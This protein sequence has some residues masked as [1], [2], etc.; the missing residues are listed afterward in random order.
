M[1]DTK[2]LIEIAQH[3][4]RDAADAVMLAELS[5]PSMKDWH[6]GHIRHL[7]RRAGK[8]LKAAAVLPRPRPLFY[9]VQGE[10]IT[11]DRVGAL[12]VGRLALSTRRA[13]ALL[14]LWQWRGVARFA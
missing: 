3:R 12:K 14:A 2:T 9:N 10:R 5:R 8:A 11:V 7:L 4:L 13:A 1:K 6:A